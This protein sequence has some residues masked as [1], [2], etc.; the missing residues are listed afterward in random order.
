MEFIDP[1]STIKYLELADTMHV[2]DMG[3]GSGHYTIALAN[4]VKAG[5]VYS[6]EVQK[7]VLER[8]RHELQSLHITNVEC[9]WVN[10]EKMNST[11]LADNSLDAAVVSNVLFQIEDT[12]TFMKEIGR[13]IKPGGKVLFIDWSDSFGGMGP[14]SDAIITKDKATA[15]F[16]Q[17]GFSVGNDVPCGSHHYGV[18]FRKQ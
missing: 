11:K 10:M 3:S 12:F 7:E 14:K 9:L 16:A 17:V 5:K 8:L 6:F 2:A 15:L 18:L 4:V 13:I 1:A